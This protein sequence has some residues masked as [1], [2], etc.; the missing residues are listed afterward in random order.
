MSE[1]YPLQA[2]QV[3]FLLQ[4]STKTTVFDVAHFRAP[5]D[6]RLKLVI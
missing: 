3:E 4:M 6:Y 1:N 2:F 5:Q